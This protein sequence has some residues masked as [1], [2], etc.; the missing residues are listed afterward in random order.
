MFLAT[1]WCAARRSAWGHTLRYGKLLYATASL[2]HLTLDALLAAFLIFA[3][4]RP[5]RAHRLL[6]G[7]ALSILLTSFDAN[8]ATLLLLQG[9]NTP[10]LLVT[11]IYSAYDMIAHAASAAI[12]PAA[13]PPAKVRDD[14][15][16]HIHTILRHLARRR[17]L[18]YLRR[19]SGPLPSAEA[20]RRLKLL[21][22]G[23][24]RL[25]W[26]SRARPTH[27]YVLLPFF[28]CQA[29]SPARSSL[30]SECDA[31]HQALPAHTTAGLDAWC[32]YARHYL[33]QHGALRESFA[34]M[35]T[36]MAARA[37]M[38][39]RFDSAY[40]A[41]FPTAA[42]QRF[43]RGRGIRSKPAAWHFQRAVLRFPFQPYASPR[44]AITGAAY[45]I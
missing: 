17:L 24:R 43:Q 39:T 44:L 34:T 38:A 3:T 11:A 9:I 6:S 21:F 7:F 8:L 10:M 18:I 26:Y 4:C 13:S 37:S 40:R 27:G 14:D 12:F 45:S 20:W 23:G 32:S 30:A 2:I 41:H 16:A 5:G 28:S 29:E 15:D 1:L 35:F 31:D 19:R 25:L 22:M 36:H 33:V 42:Q